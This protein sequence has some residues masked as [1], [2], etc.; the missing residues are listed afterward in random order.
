MLNKNIKRILNQKIHSWAD[1]VDDPNIKNLILSN[2]IISGG[3]IVSLIENQKPNDYD[4]YF[5]NLDSLQK[6]AE[7][8]VD[9]FTKMMSDPENHINS[10]SYTPVVQK[11]VWDDTNNKW[12][13]IHNKSTSQQ[14]DIRLRVFVRSSGGV[15][16]DFDAYEESNEFRKDCAKIG[17]EIKDAKIKITENSY[18]PVFI[19]ANAITLSDDIQL[20]LRFYGEPEEI[21]TNYDYVHC[22]CTYTMWDDKL[23][24]PCD[25]WESIVNKN[26]HYIG[27]KYPLCSLIRARKFMSR[28]WQINAGQFV[29]IALQLS[30]LDLKNLHVFEEQLIGV[31]SVY[32]R[33]VIDAVQKMKD[34]DSSYVSDTRYLIK[35]INEVFDE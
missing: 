7:Y 13:V 21:H 8:Y 19:S 24:I 6:V 32:F 33:Q 22:T 30:E 2:A 5:R 29:K 16:V 31:D 26:L 3:A 28:G 34:K 4:V 27:S 12:I 11:C 17:Q 35:L 23:D 9:K 10:T 18:S 25:A 15:G 14:G 1:S 20:V